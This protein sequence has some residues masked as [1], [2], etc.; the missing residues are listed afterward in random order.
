MAHCLGSPY[1]KF[2]SE[3]EEGVRHSTLRRYASL[4]ESPVPP[5]KNFTSGQEEGG[6]AFNLTTLC[7]VEGTTG[8]PYHNSLL[9]Q[10]RLLDFH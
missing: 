5:Y 3:Q 8:S 7:V 2:M 6:A 9:P 4:R 10:L 1:K